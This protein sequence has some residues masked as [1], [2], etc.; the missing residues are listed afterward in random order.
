MDDKTRAR[1]FQAMDTLHVKVA[2]E[3]MVGDGLDK[4]G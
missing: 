2:C 4:Q 1:L 3:Q